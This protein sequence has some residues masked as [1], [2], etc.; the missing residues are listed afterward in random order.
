MSAWSKVAA[1]SISLLML[2]PVLALGAGVNVTTHHYDNFRTGW[3]WQESSLTPTVLNSGTFGNL[4]NV[5][6][7]EEIDAQP[8]VLSGQ[9]INGGA[10]ANVA[11]VATENNTVYAINVDTGVILASNHLEA[12][13]PVSLLSNGSCS[14]NSAFVG[15]QS[16]PVIDQAAGT[17]YVVTTVGSGTPIYHLHALSVSTLADKVAP[18]TIT[19][20]WSSSINRQRAALTLFNGGVLIPFASF[21]DHPASRGFLTYATLSG[22]PGQAALQTTTNF[23]ASIWMSGGG[24]AI[25]GNSIYFTTGNGSTSGPYPPGVSNLAETLVNVHGSSSAPLTLTFISQF[26]PTNYATLDSKDLDFGSGGVLLIPQGAPSSISGTT[27]AQFVAAAGKDANLY[28]NN[29]ALGPTY[30]QDVNVSSDCHCIYSY[31]TGSDGK[32]HVAMS[33]GSTLGLYNVL[34]SGLGFVTSTAASTGIRSDGFTT[35]VSSSTTNAGTA[36]IWTVGG[37]TS[38]AGAPL[39]L[40]AYDAGTLSKL[41]EATTGS[42]PNG[43]NA[44][45]VPVVANGK[46][47]VGSYK[48]LSIFGQPAVYSDAATFTSSFKIIIQNGHSTTF[49]GYLTPGS[50]S[51]P[52]LTGGKTVTGFSDTSSSGGSFSGG[53]LYVSGFTSDPGIKWLASATGNGVTK[54]GYNASYFYSNGAAQWNW[55]G[56][57]FGFPSSGTV[58]AKIVHR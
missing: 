51:P 39:V 20:P 30:F 29:L 15:I 49:R 58:T 31:F 28:I 47:L 53:S 22:A 56:S 2:A 54:L 38:A 25:Y 13:F 6:V 10:A 35:S 9:S 40:G 18:L 36:V 55:A 4:F 26:T 32:G 12:A 8:L 7:D 24:P 50:W 45:A 1:Y 3:N 57:Y 37:P 34:T 43:N 23:L 14:N 44:N 33:A 19:N 48:Q 11:Y 21:C 42:W 5:S 46:V 16:T 27:T 52:T 17:L 41:F